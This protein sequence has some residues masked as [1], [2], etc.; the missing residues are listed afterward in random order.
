MGIYKEKAVQ[1]LSEYDTEHIV[2]SENKIVKLVSKND[3]RNEVLQ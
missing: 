3:T 1:Y 2:L